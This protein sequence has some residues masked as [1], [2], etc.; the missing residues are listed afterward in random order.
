MPNKDNASPATLPKTF[1]EL[2]FASKE[3]YN[4][5][6]TNVTFSFTDAS[7][8]K[9]VGISSAC[10]SEGKSF[11]AINL[12]ASLAEAGNAVLLIDCDM[13]RP[14]IAKSLGKPLSPGLSN[15]LV[16]NARDV[17][18]SG[19]LN[20]NLS[21]VTAGDIPPN[22]SELLGSEKMQAVVE[23]FR[24]HFDYIILDLPPITA[25]ADPLIVTKLVDGMVVVV[26]HKVTK[27]GDIRDSIRQ[28]KMTG[29]RILGFVYNGYHSSSSYGY[30]KYGKYK[31][32]NY[33]YT[34]E[35][36]DEHKGASA[37]QE[38]KKQ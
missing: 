37:G 31:Y 10:L 21:I 5:L 13:R 12:A 2:N 24:E 29:V 34:S 27:R 23:F 8:G 30:K 26:R 32:S 7:S 17:V 38:G 9:V 25:V 15:L 33:Y 28:L 19:V 36:K 4:L 35:H 1:S 6:R 16:S 11:T 22:P 18:H 20:D 14:S 3:A